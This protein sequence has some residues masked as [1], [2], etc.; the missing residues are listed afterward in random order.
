MN[1]FYL[2]SFDHDK[3]DADALNKVIKENSSFITW[4]HYLSSTY[5]VKTKLSLSD[6]NNDIRAKWPNQR[7]MI[8]EI[9]PTNYNGWLQPDAWK[10]FAD[11]GKTDTPTLLQDLAE[12]TPHA[13]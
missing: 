11:N 2:I 5:I 8:V 3:A 13:Q 12:N 9:K 4:W 1:N 6:V 10:W 7:F